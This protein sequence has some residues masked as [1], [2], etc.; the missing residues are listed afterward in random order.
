MV[1]FTKELPL[2]ERVLGNDLK[3]THLQK[4]VSLGTLCFDVPLNKEVTSWMERSCRQYYPA[5]FYF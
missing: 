2:E 1:R 3:N 4:K 5:I